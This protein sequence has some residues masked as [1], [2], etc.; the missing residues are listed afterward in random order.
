VKKEDIIAGIIFMGI[1]IFLFIQ[2]LKF[3]KPPVQGTGPSFWPQVILTL[4]VIFSI[5]LIINGLTSRKTGAAGTA[6]P[7][8]ALNVKSVPKSVWGILVTTL[9]VFFF[10]Q[11]GYMLSTFFFLIILINVI[12]F[13]LR[14]KKLITSAIQSLLML[15]MIY[16]IFD[17]FLKV[18]L[19]KGSFF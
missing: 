1:S 15:G 4:M 9:F 2:T 13:D 7:K 5:A 14:P 12:N 10:K 11:L 3:P 8:V 6:R 18:N 19:P 16:L 17:V